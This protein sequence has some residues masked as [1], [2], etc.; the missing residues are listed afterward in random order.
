[1]GAEIGQDAL[2]ALESNSNIDLVLSDVVL[3]GAVDGPTLARLIADRYPNVRVLLISGFAKNTLMS[4]VGK[5][6]EVIA[7]PF[8]ISVLAQKIRQALDRPGAI[9]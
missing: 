5:D 9:A 8:D 4:N 6:K 2:I 7:R 1:L 3:P